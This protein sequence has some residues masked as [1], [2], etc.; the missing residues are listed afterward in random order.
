MPKGK[1][2]TRRR[3][4][5]VRRTPVGDPRRASLPNLPPP[6][7]P[8][9]PSLSRPPIP[10]LRRS[11]S[12]SPLSLGQSAGVVNPLMPRPVIH[13]PVMPT[14]VIPGG[15]AY[16]WSL[17]ASARPALF[18][19]P[20]GAAGGV[21]WASSAP[22][23]PGL[24]GTPAGA[25]GGG[26]D[27]ASGSA[28]PRRLTATERARVGMPVQST[29][30]R[31]IFGLPAVPIGEPRVMGR[32]ATANNL[33]FFYGN[34]IAEGVPMGHDADLHHLREGYV[35]SFHHNLNNLPHASALTPA[36]PVKPSAAHYVMIQE[37]NARNRGTLRMVNKNGSYVGIGQTDPRLS[38][39]S[40]ID[41]LNEVR[42]ILRDPASTQA[43]LNR[44]DQLLRMARIRN[45]Q[46]AAEQRASSG[47]GVS[48]QIAEL[49][50]RLRERTQSVRNRVGS[51]ARGLWNR[52][53]RRNRSPNRSGR[54]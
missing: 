36:K 52:L 47:M 3:S 26:V 33:P 1:S 20:G 12:R 10:L 40:T 51:G 2:K 34:E 37:M 14:P 54:E 31:T 9:F 17:P 49:F 50:Q 24:F 39:R 45:E 15:S 27:W 8:P 22:R 46:D 43:D 13:G 30:M 32:S 4:S 21:A 23:A 48:E 29:S 53:T 11:V 28:A 19:T 16:D 35:N 42:V 5:N 41:M 6:V 44:V 7:P 38:T 18:G 25:A